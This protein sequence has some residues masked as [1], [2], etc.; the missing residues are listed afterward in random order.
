MLFATFLFSLMSVCVKFVS[1]SYSTVEIVMY[2]SLIGV[3]VIGLLMAVRGAAF[4]T[5]FPLAH[6]WRGVVGA[7]AFGLWFFSVAKLP[8]A[9]AMTLNYMSPIWIA[10]M[11]FGIGWWR[12]KMHFEWRLVAAVLTSFVGV[13]LLLKPSI[14]ADQLLWGAIGLCS[15]MLASL[16][17]LQVRQLGILGE[18]EDRVVFYFC[19]TGTVGGAIACW[20]GAIL[21]GSDGVVWHAHDWR[22]FML[23][24]AIGVFAAGGQMAMTR[25]YH[26]GKTLVTA[27]L[28]YTGIV[29]SSIWGILIWDDSLGWMGWL[30]MTIIIAS[31]VVATFFDVRHKQAVAFTAAKDML[32][33]A[34]GTEG[35]KYTKGKAAD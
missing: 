25:A 27:N 30:G 2:R 5:R 17:Y 10:A 22:G 13:A 20:I 31:G 34:D 6:L 32:V 18:P 33:A 11:L 23:L 12:G 26:L 4:K 21:P 15:G 28:Q 9:T 7:T 24:T 29:F 1:D 19:I 16:A 14:H 8:L 3:V 35:S